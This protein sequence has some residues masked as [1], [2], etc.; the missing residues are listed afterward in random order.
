M[1]LKIETNTKLTGYINNVESNYKKVKELANKITI[2]VN[3]VEVATIKDRGIE[4]DYVYEINYNQ[5]EYGFTEITD[6]E[7][8]KRLEKEVEELKGNRL[9]THTCRPPRYCPCTQIYAIKDYSYIVTKEDREELNGC[10]PYYSNKSRRFVIVNMGNYGGE[11]SCFDG[12]VVPY[13]CLIRN[14]YIQE[15][16]SSAI[17]K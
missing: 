16:S 6:K 4:S 14:I 11:V 15:K 13:D 12:S 3:H 1:K 7:R 10:D 5:K 8:I 17:E 2:I 9:K